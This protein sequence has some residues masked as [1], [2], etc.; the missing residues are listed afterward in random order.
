M[1]IALTFPPYRRASKDCTSLLLLSIYNSL[2]KF[3][4]KQTRKQSSEQTIVFC[5]KFSDK[6][7]LL[8]LINESKSGLGIGI[9][10]KLLLDTSVI[11]ALI[12]FFTCRKILF[13]W[14]KINTKEMDVINEILQV[15]G[16]FTLAEEKAH[17][18][19]DNLN[20]YASNQLKNVRKELNVRET[21]EAE[22]VLYALKFPKKLS[23]RDLS[24]IIGILP[25]AYFVGS[26]VFTF[27]CFELLQSNV[28]GLNYNDYWIFAL[29]HTYLIL[30]I[31]LFGVL[32]GVAGTNE[33][34][35]ISYLKEEDFKA[36]MR[37]DD[38]LYYMFV[39]TINIPLLTKL[40]GF[41]TGGW[42]YPILL[43]L[44]I[45]SMIVIRKFPYEHMFEQP[46]VINIAFI[47]FILVVFGMG[48]N[49]WKLSEELK[50]PT[51][52]KWHYI[53]DNIKVASNDYS[54]VY[55]GNSSIVFYKRDIGEF[56]VKNKKDM[57]SFVGNR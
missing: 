11:D 19:V 8:R 30:P 56:L 1:L 4:P 5:Q 40:L 39:L 48:I 3:K 53:F 21:A 52:T 43:D 41:D 9:T 25:V 55:E 27:I 7:E 6:N 29:P 26:F 47:F 49:G 54:F 15:L 33:R 23:L 42:V 12:C 16:S 28:V 13:Q 2:R 14:A 20:K 50:E 17:K 36:F 45:I 32:V 44:L 37:T 31:T 38:I 34:F 51:S 10:D 35:K 57:K 22:N 24:L 18:S 46:F